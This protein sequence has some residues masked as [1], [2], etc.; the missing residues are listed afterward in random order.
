MVIQV[1]KDSYIAPHR[2]IGKTKTYI[3]LEGEMYVVFFDSI[4]EIANKFILRPWGKE[5]STV[6]RFD[7]SPWHTILS[8]T[9]TST[10]VETAEGPYKPESTEFAEWAPANKDTKGIFWLEKKIKGL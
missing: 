2:Q 5:G 4:G 8:T 9:K 6:L 7:S 3:I 1:L 10:Y